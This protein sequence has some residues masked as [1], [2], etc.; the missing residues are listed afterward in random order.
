MVSEDFI[1]EI[2]IIGSFVQVSDKRIGTIVGNQHSGGVFRG[3]CNVWFGGFVKD[4][5]PQIEH[6]CVAEDWKLIN[7]PVGGN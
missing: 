2:S 6:L 1:H 7:T 3:H 4:D 5:E